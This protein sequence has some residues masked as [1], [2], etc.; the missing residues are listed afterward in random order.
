MEPVELN[1]LILDLRGLLKTIISKKA[2]FVVDLDPRL[3]TTIADASQMS[4]V[5]MNLIIN[6]SDALEGRSGKIVVKTGCLNADSQLLSQAYFGEDMPECRCVFFEVSDTGAGMSKETL[7]HIFDPFFTTKIAGRG[8]G[9]AAVLGIVKSHGGVLHV[10][11][12]PGK[13][14]SFRILL[15]AAECEPETKTPVVQLMKKPCKGIKLLVV[16]DEESILEAAK[17]MLEDNGFLVLTASD[18]LQAVDLFRSSPDEIS[19]VILDVS[20]PG[21]NGAETL[22]ELRALKPNLKVILSSGYSEKAAAKLFSPEDMALFVKKP[23]M[24][25]QLLRKIGDALNCFD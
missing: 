2:D 8:L 22:R 17:S 15:R 24:S 3:Q 13:G 25:S 16:D 9:L 14:T 23:Y 21:M 5:I 10:Y 20:M 4:Q 18:G 12:E 19:A 7:S 11:S 6:A 1:R